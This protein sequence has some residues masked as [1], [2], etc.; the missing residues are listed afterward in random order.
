[1]NRTT[2]RKRR[3]NDEHPLV[4]IAIAILAASMLWWAADGFAERRG[5]EARQ[6]D[7]VRLWEQR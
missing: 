2:N 6:R 3:T 5:L 4:K 7:A 1:M